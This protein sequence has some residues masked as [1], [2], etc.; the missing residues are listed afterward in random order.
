MLHNHYFKRETN[1]VYSLLAIS[2]EF[3][4]E[5][6]SA[7]RIPAVNTWGRRNFSGNGYERLIGTSGS[8][9][10]TDHA[11]LPD[12]HTF[13]L[14]L[15]LDSRYCMKKIIRDS[16][17]RDSE[18]G[19]QR[20]NEKV[21]NWRTTLCRTNERRGSRTS[22]VDV[23]PVRLIYST[24]A[25]LTSRICFLSGRSANTCKL[26]PVCLSLPPI[27]TLWAEFSYERYFY[28]QDNTINTF[29]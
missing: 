24:C 19:A 9:I 18:R 6:T 15:L 28:T 29:T 7:R 27:G 13:R 1:V 20:T 8:K 14:K 16:E 5:K 10:I 17:V 3:T 2:L 12:E 26:A 23:S 25:D 22:D 4:H 21:N 11:R